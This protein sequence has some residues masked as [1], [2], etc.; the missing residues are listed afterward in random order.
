MKYPDPNWLWR[1]EDGP[2][3]WQKVMNG[4]EHSDIVVTA[5]G[6]VGEELIQ[7]DVDN[8]YNAEFAERLSRDPL[9]RGPIHLTMGRF[10]PIDVQVF[11]KS[12][13]GC[14]VANDAQVDRYGSWNQNS[15]TDVA[16]GVFR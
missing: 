3:D 7:E 8:R 11:V 14:S 9:F 6:Y 4:A 5:P 15:E 10:A 1:Y 16:E 2:I 13:L 12:T